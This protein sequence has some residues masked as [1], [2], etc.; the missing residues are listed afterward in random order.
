[1]LHRTVVNPNP[2][3]KLKTGPAIH[4]VK[5]IS[6]K[7]FFDIAIEAKASPTELPHE[8][9]VRPRRAALIPEMHSYITSASTI[10]FASMYIQIIDIKNDHS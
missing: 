7:P 5:A 8:S 1:M 3:S 2:S 4:P 6:P 9:T 10:I